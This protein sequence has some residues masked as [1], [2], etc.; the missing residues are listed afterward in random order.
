MSTD[1]EKSPRR[2]LSC[3]MKNRYMNRQLFTDVIIWCF[4]CVP[5]LVYFIWGTPYTQGFYCDDVSI[6]L[7]YKSNTISTPALLTAGL[8]LPLLTLFL[9]EILRVTLGR[10]DTFKTQNIDLMM[11]VKGFGIFLFGTMVNKVFTEITKYS[12]GRLRPNFIDVCRP[13]FTS[14]NCSQGYITDY[15]CTTTEHGARE[16]RDSR[17]S[18]PS[19]HASFGVFCSVYAVLYMQARL[20]VTSSYLLKPTLQSALL[21]LSAWCCLTRVT[22]NRHF[23]SDVIAGCVLGIVTA[24]LTFY[25]VALDVLQTTQRGEVERAYS[26]NSETEPATPAPLLRNSKDHSC[27][28]YLNNPLHEKDRTVS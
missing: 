20:K 6:R 26:V 15:T 9:T 7:P 23:P 4:V 16:I 1:C 19:G 3:T 10:D 22:D 18:F 11:A 17:L 13:D 14:I 12:V 24:W 8:A 27:T 2:N 21:L 5:V 28:V 25:K